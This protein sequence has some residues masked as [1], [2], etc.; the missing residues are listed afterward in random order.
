MTDSFFL[1]LLC[2]AKGSDNTSRDASPAT[3]NGQI[4]DGEVCIS[5]SATA[6]KV[7]LNS[8]DVVTKGSRSSTTSSL[9]SLDTNTCNVSDVDNMPIMTVTDVERAISGEAHS[10]PDGDFVHLSNDA[11]AIMAS[12]PELNPNVSSSPIDVV[13]RAGSRQAERPISLDLESL[14]EGVSAHSIFAELS[15]QEPDIIGQVDTGA[16]ITAMV[17]ELDTVLKEN[18][19]LLQVK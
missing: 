3:Q 11:V 7:D 2:V 5:P 19:E 18:K 14:P 1:G 9:Q 8:S 12:T 16:D 17:G 10:P 6:G 4:A 15:S 13:R